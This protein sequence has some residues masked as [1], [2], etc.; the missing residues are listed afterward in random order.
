VLRQRSAGLQ[1]ANGRQWSAG[2]QPA[3]GRQ[4]SAG[5]QPAN[6]LCFNETNRA[7]FFTCSELRY[8]GLQTRAPLPGTP[9][10][11]F[12]GAGYKP[13]LRCLAPRR[14]ASGGRVANPRSVRAMLRTPCIRRG[15][16]ALSPD[17]RVHT[18]RPARNACRFG[19]SGPSTL[20]AKADLFDREPG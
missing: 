2:L 16:D 9:P 6:H 12:G 18:A 19:S 5:L 7:G 4:W 15:A 3:N 14:V 13:A 1:P 8:C 20:T 17:Y 11:G 10:R